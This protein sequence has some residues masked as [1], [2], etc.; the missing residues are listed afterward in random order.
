MTRQQTPNP[1]A[2]V[3]EAVPPRLEHSLDEQQVPLVPVVEVQ[4]PCFQETIVK[5]DKTENRMSATFKRKTKFLHLLTASGLAATVSLTVN[6]LFCGNVNGLFCGREDMV[7]TSEDNGEE[8]TA[9][10]GMILLFNI[11]TGLS[12]SS[13]V[14]FL[15]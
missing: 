3:P 10:S 15:F 1:L 2:H 9:S 7:V 12:R 6:G 5:R 14:I 11:L 13:L 8:R 4:G